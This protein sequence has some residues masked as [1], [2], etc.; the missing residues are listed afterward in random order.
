MSK[1]L[2]VI[3]KG[4]KQ[5]TLSEPKV[6]SSNEYDALEMDAKVELIQSLIPL[7][8]MRV[9]EMLEDEVASL[10]GER[11]SRNEG[12]PSL[13]RHGSNRSSVKLA[14]Q[15]HAIRVP[16]VRNRKTQSEVPLESWQAMKGSGNVDETLL[17]RVLYGISCRNYEAASEAVPGAIGLSSSTVSRQFVE[18]SA[19][20]L[21]AFSERDLAD[22]DITAL[23]LDG[24]SF[25]EDSMIIVLGITLTGEKVILGF[26]QAG[27]ENARVV[28]EFLESLLDRNLKIDQGLLVVIDGSKGLHSAVRSAFKGKVL[29][30]RC[31]WHKRENVVSYLP[32]NEQAT[33]RSR[34]QKAYQKATYKETKTALK[35]IERELQNRNISAANSLLEGLEETLTLHRLGLFGLLGR[36]F[37]TSNCIESIM[38]QVEKRCGKVTSWKNA[39]QK[40][41]WLASAL[42]DIEPRL[43]RVMGHK[44]LPLLRKKLKEELGINKK[45]NVA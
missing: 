7:G 32:K 3:E 38:S 14:G 1:I 40:H 13:V 33:M 11:Y 2:K 36:S 26:V 35:K 27:T 41:R 23:F 20:Q 5:R 15:K 29:I 8:L 31:Q 44:H 22:Y 19:Q 17:R 28:H 21:K 37:K 18:A 16:R 24:K 34:L 10:A 9:A 39:S 45:Q 6:M 25:A 12:D 42:V 30:Q 4:K 43:N